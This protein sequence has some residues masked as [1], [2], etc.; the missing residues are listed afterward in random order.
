[1]KLTRRQVILFASLVVLSCS[2]SLWLAPH[3]RT[4]KAKELLKLGMSRAETVAILG[5]PTEDFAGVSG[6]GHDAYCWDVSNGCICV[7]FINDSAIRIESGDERFG[8]PLEWLRS[9][10]YWLT[11]FQF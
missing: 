7:C 4:T 11:G 2:F 9:K 10:V 8:G 1:V 3:G 6:N 5:K